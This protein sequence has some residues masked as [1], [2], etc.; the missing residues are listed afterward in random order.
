M[1]WLGLL[2][3]MWNRHLLNKLFYFHQL[4]WSKNVGFVIFQKHEVNPEVVSNSNVTFI[5]LFYFKQS[6]N[7]FAVV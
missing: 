1:F 7:K 4:N 5:E 2:N 6:L 3:Y